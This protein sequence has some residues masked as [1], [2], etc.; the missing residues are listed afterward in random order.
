MRLIPLSTAG[1]SAVLLLGISPATFGQRNL[2]TLGTGGNIL[3][4]GIPRN[5]G[6]AVPPG[7]NA[8]GLAAGVPLGA[9]GSASGFGARGM[10]SSFGRPFPNNGIYGGGFYGSGARRLGG[11]TLIVP[12]PIYGSGGYTVVHNPPPGTYDPIFGV[13]NPADPAGYY[14]QAPQPSP[15]VVINQDFQTDTV[16]PQFRDYSNSN[17]PPTGPS[18]PP[19]SPPAAAAG[20]PQSPETPMLLIA[21]QDHTIFPVRAYWVEGDTLKYV[22]INGAVNQAS[23]SLVDRELSH[24]LNDERGVSIRFPGER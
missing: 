12:Y 14:Q 22:T 6:L 3:R 7:V 13:Y 11:S 21:M 1:L 17:L 19:P 5:G 18:A 23:L 8:P 10:G 24:R 2:P 4:P 16:R 15:T 20:G 9:A